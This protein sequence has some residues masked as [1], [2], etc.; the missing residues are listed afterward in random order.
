[1][2][3]ALGN[4]L[5]DESTIC[6]WRR[7][8]LALVSTLVAQPAGCRDVVT[9]VAAT[10]L[11]C[12]QVF[13]SALQRDNCAPTQAGAGE[14]GGRRQPHEPTAIN[15]AALLF[16]KGKGTKT[17]Q[18]GHGIGQKEGQGVFPPS[19]YRTKWAPEPSGYPGKTLAVYRPVR[20]LAIYAERTTL[21]RSTN[22]LGIYR[23]GKGR[24][25]RLS[26]PPTHD[27]CSARAA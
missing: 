18:S 4:A 6:L 1:M 7:G 22:Q 11:L 19:G 9:V 15:A 2:P 5:L 27:E 25:S 14:V 13:G 3:F 12:D 23:A 20:T 24:L 16:M 17:G 8:R 10:R 26:Q 21:T